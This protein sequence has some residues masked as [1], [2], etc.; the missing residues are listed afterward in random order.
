MI[1]EFDAIDGIRA[2]CVEGCDSERCC[3]LP[4]VPIIRVISIG[5]EQRIAAGLARRAERIVDRF[6]K[7]DH[8]VRYTGIIVYARRRKRKRLT[9]RTEIQRRWERQR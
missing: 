9:T 1:T 6:D 8:E 5:Y 7:P 4:V 3:G 2:R